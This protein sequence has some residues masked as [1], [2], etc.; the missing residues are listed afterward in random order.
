VFVE[1]MKKDLGALV[2]A[3]SKKI[4]A[5]KKRKN[6]QSLEHLISG[7]GP[8]STPG[9][10]VDL[11]GEE[12]PEELAQDSAKRQRVRVP[13]EDPITLIK[14]VPVVLKRETFSSFPGYGPSR[15]CAAPNPPFSWMIQS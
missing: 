1:K 15:S 9:P 10:V 8:S 3:A 5:K 11:E 12:P 6:V 14:A 13:S 4:S 2:N 7:S